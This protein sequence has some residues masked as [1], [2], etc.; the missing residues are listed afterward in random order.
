MKKF[1]TRAV[2]PALAAAVTLTPA[3]ADA[4]PLSVVPSADAAAASAPRTDTFNVAS[5]NVL[6]G[7]HTA[8]GV[9]GPV[10]LAPPAPSTTS[11]E[12]NVSVGR[13]AGVRGPAVRRVRTQHQGRLDRGRRPHPQ[14]QEIDVRNAIAVRADRFEVLTRTHLPI[15]YFHGKRV[16]IPVVKVRSKLTNDVLGHQHPQPGRRAR[17]CGQ[18][19][20]HLDPASGRPGHQLRQRGETVLLTGDMNE[21]QPYFCK[22]T[23]RSASCTRRRVGRW[24][25]SAATPRA[26]G[27][28]GSS[29]PVT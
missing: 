19:A 26:T 23:A 11:S 13:P 16:N 1:A 18:V 5:F 25:P 15:T 22:M 9:P 17:R 21:K 28:T 6:G 14:R 29:A 2:V 27:S 3:T 4:T 10:S 20:C 8:R 12:H 7:S 24:V